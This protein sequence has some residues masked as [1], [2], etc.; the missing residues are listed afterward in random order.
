MRLSM[1]TSDLIQR[2]GQ[3][4]RTMGHSYV[5]SAHMLLTLAREPGWTGQLLRGL[6][7]DPDLS[8]AMA[9]LLYGIGSADLPLPQ[10]LT[11]EAKLLLRSAARE[12]KQENCREIRLHH[13]LLALARDGCG[14]AAELLQ[15]SGVGA[16]ALFTHTVEYLNWE[17]SAPLVKK[18]EAVSTRLLE[19]F[20]E[21]LKEGKLS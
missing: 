1:L 3:L 16:D 5:G 14:G 2:S 19:Q 15:I 9:R 21:D 10:G 18:K 20:S 4:A 6:G 13:L 17:R 8:E 7:V 11:G 12:A